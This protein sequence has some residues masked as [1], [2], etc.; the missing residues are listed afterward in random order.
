MGI[1]SNPMDML[2]T[3]AAPDRADCSIRNSRTRSKSPKRPYYVHVRE[4]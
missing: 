3:I 2:C 4:E 1:D